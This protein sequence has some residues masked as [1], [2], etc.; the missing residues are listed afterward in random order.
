MV[1]GQA[2]ASDVELALQEK[3]AEASNADT[4]A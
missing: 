4:T 3:G 2:T 1:N